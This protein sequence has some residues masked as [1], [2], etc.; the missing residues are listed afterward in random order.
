MFNWSLPSLKTLA[1]TWSLCLG[2]A[3]LLKGS[4]EWITSTLQCT[5][6]DVQ[7]ILSYNS[8]SWDVPEHISQIHSEIFKNPIC[9]EN[10]LKITSAWKENLD[11]FI[12]EV[13]SI[14]EWSVVPWDT[15]NSPFN[16]SNLQEFYERKDSF[17]TQLQWYRNGIEV[18]LLTML[19][20]SWFLDNP[21][22]QKRF[23][24]IIPP[25]YKLLQNMHSESIP[26]INIA[27]TKEAT[28]EETWRNTKRDI[29]PVVTLDI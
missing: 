27:W 5:S 7:W 28:L 26:W 15:K 12:I 8:L 14:Y 11:S 4:T 9:R 17:M 3:I 22:V 24:E 1:V 23:S 16:A 2:A 29:Q 25:V 21:H 10:F 20:L 19:H 13:D 6:T 18:H